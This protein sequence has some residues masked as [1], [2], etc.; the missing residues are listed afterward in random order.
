MTDSAR[1]LLL[2][3][4]EVDPARERSLA[5]LRT[6]AAVLAGLGAVAMLLSRLPFVMLLL[7]VLALLVSAGWLAQARGLRRRARAPEE[8]FLAL[9]QR[10]FELGLGASRTWVPFTTVTDIDV[11]D[12]RLDIVVAR[13]GQAGLRLE[14]RYP[15]VEIYALMHTLR[16]AWHDQNDSE[17]AR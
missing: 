13:E 11:D 5:R 7:A 17:D 1:G 9:H 2:S 4:Y 8:H 10:G 15:G 3:R 14:S 16:K 6:S 12:E